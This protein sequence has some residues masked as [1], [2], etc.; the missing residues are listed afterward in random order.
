MKDTF[1]F[2]HDYNTRSDSK[3]KNLIRKQGMLGY[4]VYWSIVEDLYNNA[5]ALQLDYDSIAYDLRIDKEIV[6]SVINDFDLFI[7]E[8]NSFGSLSVQ[9]RLDKRKEKS[10]KARISAYKRW[11]KDAN[12]MQTQCAPNAIKE[13]KVNKSIIKENIF[14]SDI[15]DCYNNIL[16][17]FPEHLHPENSDSWLKTIKD[18]NQIDKIP[19]DKILEIV[20]KTRADKFWSKNFLSLTK[21]RKKNR[22]GIKYVVYFNE[23][24]KGKFD[25][26]EELMR[27]LRKKQSV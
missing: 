16:N 11:G 25:P 4:G 24:I 7:I 20:K 18:L 9:N 26:A 14:S 6:R 5:N 23:Q 10:Q 13:S 22:D 3:I 15:Y 2:S 12:A 17:Y 19:F 27:Q 21:L 1:Y 8:N